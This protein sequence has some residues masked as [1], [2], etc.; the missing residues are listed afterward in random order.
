VKAFPINKNG[1]LTAQS[2][3]VWKGR[4]C[5]GV[6]IAGNDRWFNIN[7]ESVFGGLWGYVWKNALPDGLMLKGDDVELRP[8]LTHILR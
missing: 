5:T 3:T 7:P 6:S 1:N 8:K 2:I 4:N